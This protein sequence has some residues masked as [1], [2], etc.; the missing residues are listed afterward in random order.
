[1]TITNI[2]IGTIANDGTGDDL[3]EAFIKV[4]N[5]FT[6]LNARSAESTTVTNK[7][8]D[9]ANGGLGTR[10][11]IFS[12]KDGVDLQFKVLEAGP[13]V[14]LSSDEN[15]IT[16]NATGI[17][18]LNMTG[19]TGPVISNIGSG[20]T[21]QY[22][23][24][25]GAKTRMLAIP[26]ATFPTLEIESLLAN[27]SNP[28]LSANLVGANNDI[29]GVDVIQAANVQSLVYNIDVRTRNS[30]IGFDMGTIT[31]DNAVPPAITFQNALDYFFY[32]N[33]IDMGTIG[34]PLLDNLDQGV[35]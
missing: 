26:P 4:N 8:A 34:S 27:E 7:L 17:L 1:M 13:N 6:E 35:L 15:K 23:G 32:L 12:N 20:S 5:N 18:S 2:N 3:R 22:F 16:I 14:S 19:S 21:I 24:V 31:L 25:G 10:K 28:T 29:T 33:P 9:T 11:G 30:F